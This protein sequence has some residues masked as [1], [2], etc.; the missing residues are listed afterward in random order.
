MPLKAMGNKTAQFQKVA[1]NRLRQSTEIAAK[2][3]PSR[4]RSEL[5]SDENRPSGM[6]KQASLENMLRRN[7]SNAVVKKHVP[8]SHLHKKT[9]FNALE[10]MMI[11]PTNL[12]RNDSKYIKSI[13]QSAEQAFRDIFKSPPSR[14]GEAEIPTKGMHKGSKTL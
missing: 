1:V 6:K 8:H 10:K 5:S 7:T 9:Y 3:L 12:K 14:F 13:D 11:S 2:M 4:I